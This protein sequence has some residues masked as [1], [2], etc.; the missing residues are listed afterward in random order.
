MSV[1]DFNALPN[2]EYSNLF[3]ATAFPSKCFS[4][5]TPLPVKNS[6]LLNFLDDKVEILAICL[7]KSY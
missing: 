5:K 3:N 7:S 6:Y 1:C 4:G 2:G